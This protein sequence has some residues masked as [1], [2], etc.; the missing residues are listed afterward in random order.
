MSRLSD[1]QLLVYAMADLRTDGLG[2]GR[3]LKFA[4]REDVDAHDFNLAGVPT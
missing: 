4:R 1:Q 2:V 3:F